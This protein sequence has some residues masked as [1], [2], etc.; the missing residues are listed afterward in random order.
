MSDFDDSGFEE[1]GY[2]SELD[3]YEDTGR[4]PKFFR[5]PETTMNFENF[6]EM[7]VDDL[8][9]AYRNLRDQ[10][11]TDRKGYKA[12]EQFMKDKMSTISMVLRDR[13]DTIGVESFKTN[14]GT[15]Y[16]N[17]KVKF[18]VPGWLDLVEYVKRTSNFQLFQKRVSPNAVKEIET[19]TGEL[20]PGVE[21]LVEVEFAVRSPTVRKSNA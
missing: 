12:R 15:A 10:L 3:D 11:G 6:Q 8:I 4:R 14:F 5:T 18:Q 2:F 16:R 20:P 17:V 13:A 21:K 7:K 1:D 19:E 9:L